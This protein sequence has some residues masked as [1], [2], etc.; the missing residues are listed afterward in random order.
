VPLA[1]PHLVVPCADER[2]GLVGGE[3]AL[4]EHEEAGSPDGGVVDLLHQVALCLSTQHAGEFTREREGRVR[5]HRRRYASKRVSAQHQ[6]PK[7]HFEEDQFE[8][9]GWEHD[10]ND[11]INNST[12]R[13][14][15][16]RNNRSGDDKKKK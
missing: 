16:T 1:P 4:L 11:A 5:A 9:T 13:P 3:A 2:L 10:D 6:E 12:R 7:E 14:N 15:K 8:A